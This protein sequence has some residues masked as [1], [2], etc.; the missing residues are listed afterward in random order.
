MASTQT[1]PGPTHLLSGSGSLSTQTHHHR[2]IHHTPRWPRDGTSQNILPTPLP[3]GSQHHMGRPNALHPTP[4]HTIRSQHQPHSHHSHMACSEVQMGNKYP[5]HLA[6]G[7]RVL[8]T[9]EAMGQRQNNHI[10]QEQHIGPP[11]KSSGNC[12]GHNGQTN[13]AISTWQRLHTRTMESSSHLHAHHLPSHPSQHAQW[14]SCGIFQ[15]RSTPETSTQPTHPHSPMATQIQSGHNHSWHY[16]CTWLLP[17]HSHWILPPQQAHPQPQSHS[18]RPHTR[19]RTPQLPI[20][21][22]PS[23]RTNMATNPG[24]GH[25]KSNITNPCQHT[26][27][28]SRSKLA[29]SIPTTTTTLR[30][31]TWPLHFPS[32]CGQSHD[33]SATTHLFQPPLPNPRTTWLLST[34]NPVRAGG[35]YTFPGFYPQ[36]CKPLHHLQS[37]YISLANTRRLL[38]RITPSHTQRPLEPRHHTPQVHLATKR[39]SLLL[40]NTPTMLH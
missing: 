15:Q 23:P 16:T 10:I 33:H 6:T 9:E 39:C 3:Q 24:H 38:S 31:S 21:H 29:T 18:H 14:R 32:L 34:P 8:E 11:A 25:R 5:V 1:T 36:S 4:R 37:S 7:I 22:L 30:S 17:L 13:L 2:S 28:A 35:R 27:H 20:Q 40:R 19:H 26:H 12:I